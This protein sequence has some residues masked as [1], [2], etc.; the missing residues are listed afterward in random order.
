MYTV[1]KSVDI[2]FA[3]HV[4]G[5]DGACI[6]IHGHTW[7]FEVELGA[8]ELDKMGFV[9]DFKQLKKRVL[10]PVH[11]LLDHS[12]ALHT[13]TLR[14][15]MEP[16]RNLGD[17]LYS[18]RGRGISV[19]GTHASQVEVESVLGYK[20]LDHSLCGAENQVVGGMKIAGF[21][22]S[23]TSERLASWLYSVANDAFPASHENSLEGKQGRRIQVIQASIYETLHPVEAVASYRP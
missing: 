14:N 7:K 8:H 2:D 22:F 18:T 17:V 11:T 21:P 23:P 20:F 5:H 3:H 9:V 10:E 16:L 1:K 4:G 13:Q 19:V 15:A 12:L 6:N